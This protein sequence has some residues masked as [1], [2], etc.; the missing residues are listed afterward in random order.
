MK[1][2]YNG[3]SQDISDHYRK[4][5]FFFLRCFIPAVPLM[6][7]IATDEDYC[8]VVEMFGFHILIWTASVVTKGISRKVFIE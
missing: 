8:R 7:L 5:A 1:L 3:P 2:F 4:V 6:V